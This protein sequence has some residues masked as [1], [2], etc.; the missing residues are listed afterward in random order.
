MSFPTF[1]DLDKAAADLFGEEFDY[2]YTLKVKSSGPSNTTIT[3]NTQ[4]DTKT[5]SLVPKIALKW[6]HPS[7]FTLEKLE[8]TQDLKFNLE[9]SLSNAAPGLKLEFKGND[10]EKA[11]LS[12]TY[13]IPQATLTGEFDI[14][15]LSSVKGS[16]VAGSGAIAGGA[17]V[18]LKIAKS[19]VDS[20]TVN[21][22]VT[23]AL[24]SAFFAL[25]A[26][27]NFNNYSG[28]A[29]WNTVCPVSGRPMTVAGQVGYSGKEITAAALS[30]W[31]CCP[32]TCSFKFKVNNNGVFGGSLKKVF[33]KKFTVITAAEVPMQLNTVKLGVNCTLG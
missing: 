3:T 30:S 24:P 1:K 29:S 12:F 13:K 5:N 22:G 21:A 25:R 16:F 33:E 28:L 7:G 9:T 4:Y 8:A 15:K 19:T 17:S 20:A 11:D 27:K 26:E 32:D 10:E 23:Y 14:V 2:K 6:A 18:D 31:Q